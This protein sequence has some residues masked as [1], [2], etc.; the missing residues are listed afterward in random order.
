MVQVEHGKRH[1]S[2]GQKNQPR[3]VEVAHIC[4]VE[5]GVVGVLEL[6]NTGLV[7]GEGVVDV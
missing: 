2:V 1:S 5:E 4:I 7:V 6:I 3:Q